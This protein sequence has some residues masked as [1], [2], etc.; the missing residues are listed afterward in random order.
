MLLLSSLELPIVDSDSVIHIGVKRPS[1]TIDL[2]KLVL[3]VVLKSIVE[4]SLKRV[5]SLVNPKGKLLESRDILDSR[6]SLAEVI[7]ILLYLSSLIVYS[8]DFDKCVF[9]VDKGY[10]DDISLGALFGQALL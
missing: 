6:L 3:N 10:K 4:S 1:V 2:N 5:R 9:E 8:K 7:K